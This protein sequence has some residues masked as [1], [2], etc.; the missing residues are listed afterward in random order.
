MRPGG[1]LPTSLSRYEAVK[2][3]VSGL[4]RASRRP[5][6]PP[7]WSNQHMLQQSPRGVT[8]GRALQ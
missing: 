8:G 2:T 1:I 5:F 7:K 3:L 4:D 6:S